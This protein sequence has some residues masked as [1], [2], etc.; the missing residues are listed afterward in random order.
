MSAFSVKYCKQCAGVT[1][2][3]KRPRGSPDVIT[4]FT[5]GTEN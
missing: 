3:G 5:T 4:L 2:R 1:R